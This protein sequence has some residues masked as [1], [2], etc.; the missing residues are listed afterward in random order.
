MQASMILGLGRVRVVIRRLIQHRVGWVMSE[1]FMLREIW[2]AL[3][4]PL[5]S[6]FL[7]GIVGCLGFGY[8]RL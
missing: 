6:M 4:S 1:G 3:P 7:G 2:G 5:F 8:L